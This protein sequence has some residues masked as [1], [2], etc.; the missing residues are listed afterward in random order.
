MM[1]QETFCLKWNTYGAHLS[2]AFQDLFSESTFSDVALVCDD[3]TLLPAHKIVLSACST[4]LKN[5]LFNNPHP[6]PLIYLRGVKQHE[7]QSILRFM[8]L[9]QAT[10]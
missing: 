6:H 3:Q 9:G 10:I 8:Y 4:V 1:S 2:T 5:I 7:V